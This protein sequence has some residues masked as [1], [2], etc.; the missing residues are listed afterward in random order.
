VLARQH[1]ENFRKRLAGTGLRIEPLFRGG[2]GGAD[3]AVQQGLA[4]GSVSIVIGTQ[5]LASDK[6]RFARL[7]LVVIDEEHRFGDEDKRRLS[8]LET[9]NG[10]VH[11]L[12]MTATPIPRTLQT[13]LVG[14]RDI[15]VI[16][17]APVRR[18]PVRTYVLPFDATLLREALLREHGRGGQSFMIAPRI[19]DL[20]PLERMLREHVP[21]LSVATVHGRMKPEALENL[22]SSFASNTILI[23]GP[24]R[25]GLAQ[26]HQMRG[27]V[28]RSERRGFAYLLT[29]PGRTLAAPTLKRLHTLESME[30]LGAGMMVAIADL[31]MRGAGDLFGVAQAG[32][33]QAIGTELYQHILAAELAR[34]QGQSPPSPRPELH[35]EVAGR[36]PA[37][38]VPES[39]LRLELYRRLARVQDADAADALV[40][41][42]TDRF[43]DIPPELA[44]LISLA[45]LQ[46][47]CAA[48]GVLRLDAGPKAV[49]LTLADPEAAH[50]L[51][52]TLACAEI[53]NDRVVLPMALH[54]P[55]ARLGAI[56][57]TLGRAG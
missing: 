54:D 26:L 9:R 47:W 8:G 33:V 23:T 10:A 44:K 24:D 1:L 20:A 53:R 35:T 4:D 21:A 19:E 38:Y 27:R 7:A 30:A 55:V 16:A 12:V 17:T 18:Q 56:A 11:T 3:T 14:L 34:L 15:S 46:V 43:G 49:A 48:H 41:E 36:I 45:R 52:A 31:D 51:A 37:D 40:E 39:N 22:V 2:S 28:G 25:F 6:L 29:D 13:A 50:R 42:I 32:H 57:S 5:A